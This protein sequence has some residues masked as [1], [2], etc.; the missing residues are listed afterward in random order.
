MRLFLSSSFDQDEDTSQ[1]LS[2]SLRVEGRF[3]DTGSVGAPRTACSLLLTGR[4][5]FPSGCQARRV[6]GKETILNV[7]LTHLH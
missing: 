7:F 6:A 3:L 2:W 5:S 1:P 4:L